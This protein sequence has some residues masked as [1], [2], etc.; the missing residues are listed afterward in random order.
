MLPGLIYFWQTGISGIWWRL[1][2]NLLVAPDTC[3]DYT[4]EV[5][6]IS[7]RPDAS[8]IYYTTHTL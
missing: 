1:A 4:L 6:Q 8:R 5:V 7:L 2:K 3:S